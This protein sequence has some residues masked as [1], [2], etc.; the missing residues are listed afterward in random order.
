MPNKKWYFLLGDNLPE[1]FKEYEGKELLVSIGISSKDAHQ[2][3]IPFLGY[4]LRGG[5]E[6]VSLE[7]YEGVHK[8]F[9]QKYGKFIEK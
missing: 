6:A 4:S 9:P 1:D 2:V 7:I 3:F 5:H 8:S